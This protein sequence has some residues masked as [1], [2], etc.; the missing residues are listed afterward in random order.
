MTGMALMRL[1][2]GSIGKKLSVRQLLALSFFLLM[3]GGVL[4]WKTEGFMLSVA[5]VILLG[6][7]LAPGFPL[8]LGLVGSRYPDISATAFSFV[9]TISLTGNMIVNFSMGVIA[10]YHGIGH[11]ITLMCAVWLLMVVLGTVILRRIK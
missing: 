5:G 1:L 3:M 2:M 10:R 11:F 9:L 6:T 4:L 8:T 7:G